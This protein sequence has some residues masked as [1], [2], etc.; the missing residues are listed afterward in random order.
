MG[1]FN[2]QQ[3]PDQMP[4]GTTVSRELKR[5]SMFGWRDVIICLVII[6]VFLCTKN[7]FGLGG[8]G[9]FAPALEETRFGITA[10]DGT[11]HYFTYTEAESIELR[12]DMKTFDRGEKIEGDETRRACSGIYRNSEFG[13]YQLYVQTKLNNY[14]V[15]HA[16]DG[17]MVFN[18]ESDDTTKELYRYFNELRDEQLASGNAA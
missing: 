3:D 18:L 16:P 10:L 5:T 17:V 11:T 1:F 14:I 15:V 13:E 8:Y 12:D 6:V 4:E 9:G 2:R 7:S